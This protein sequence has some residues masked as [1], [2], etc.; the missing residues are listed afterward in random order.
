VAPG[1]AP[2]QMVLPEVEAPTPEPVELP[3]EPTLTETAEAEVPPA[4]F[5]PPPELALPD[6]EAAEPRPV[7]R[8]RDLRVVE[9]PPEPEGPELPAAPSRAAVR[10]ATEAPAAET[11]AAPRTSSGRRGGMSPARW[12]S[13][14]MAHLERLKRYPAGARARREEGTAYVRFSIDANG[15]VRSAQLARSS[16]H[17]ELDAAVLALVRRASPVPAPPPGAPQDITAPVRFTIR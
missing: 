13:R 8:P 9:R 15:N 2:P 14:L 10:A 7:A 6:R 11:A 4:A 12:Q 1:D 3:A 17:A 5:E 16:G